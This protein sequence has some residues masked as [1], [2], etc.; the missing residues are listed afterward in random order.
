M[1]SKIHWEYIKITQ[2]P[3]ESLQNTQASFL[4]KFWVWF[5]STDISTEELVEVIIKIGQKRWI[6][7]SLKEHHKFDVGSTH[8]AE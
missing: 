1:N 6:V 2:V 3:H 4:Q 8:F 5:F 7:G